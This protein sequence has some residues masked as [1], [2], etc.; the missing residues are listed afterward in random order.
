VS[1]S[2][3]E[4]SYT[5]AVAECLAVSIPIDETDR[6]RAM[7]GWCADTAR[8]VRSVAAAV[9]DGGVAGW[10]GTAASSFIVSIGTIAPISTATAHWLE[11]CANAATSYA[12]TL[13]GSA[14]RLSDLRRQLTTR[15]DATP[16]PPAS[17]DDRRPTGGAS[18]ADRNWSAC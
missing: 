2:L 3:T 11:D 5:A 6:L 15:L 4:L 7:A 12:A 18:F 9:Q 10:H 1:I 16:S 13:S 14:T 17:L 8:S